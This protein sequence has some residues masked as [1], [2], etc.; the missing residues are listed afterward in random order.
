VRAI[1]SNNSTTLQESTTV[2]HTFV[3][4]SPVMMLS[5]SIMSYL[6]GLFLYIISPLWR[7]EGKS[8]HT[9]VS[10]FR[11]VGHNM[12]ACAYQNLDFGRVHGVPGLCG[13]N[14]LFPLSSDVYGILICE[15][16]KCC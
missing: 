8:V 10:Y 2:V 1:T 16:L 9:W 7:E 4:Q 12:F 13:R 6:L 5:Y 3:L 11:P 15:D 14:I